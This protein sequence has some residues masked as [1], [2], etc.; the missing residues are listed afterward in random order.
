MLGK[1]IAQLRSFLQEHKDLDP[2]A[3]RTELLAGL[4]AAEVE[5]RREWVSSN[6]YFRPQP[7]Y[8]SHSAAQQGE[9]I[10]EYQPR[11]SYVGNLIAGCM[12]VRIEGQVGR[13]EQ[14][15]RKI[16]SRLSSGAA[17]QLAGTWLSTSEKLRALIGQLEHLS[18]TSP[19]AQL[20][21][22]AITAVQVYVGYAAVLPE[23]QWLELAPGLVES[24]SGLLQQ[25]L[26]G[27]HAWNTAQRIGLALD[28]LAEHEGAQPPLQIEIEEAIAG[29]GLVILTTA[30][31][32][33]WQGSLIKRDWKRQPLELLIALARGKGRPLGAR[34]LGFAE[35]SRQALYTACSRLRDL[36]PQSLAMLIEPADCDRE[37]GYRL[38][39]EPAKTQVISA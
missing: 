37:P 24:Q 5:S 26:R 32:V 4:A 16:Q 36:L 31:Q 2:T 33:Y 18:L 27:K 15:Q 17:R 21:Q 3:T 11:L 19:Q 13:V 12:L 1:L 28:R 38:R 20:V 9:L 25:R 30:R 29:Q 14:L 34:E 7:D 23:T 8:R 35:K 22:A 10:V 39:L 6:D